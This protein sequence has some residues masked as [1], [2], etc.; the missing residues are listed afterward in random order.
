M[1]PMPK[2]TCKSQ[3]DPACLATMFQTGGATVEGVDVV[4]EINEGGAEADEVA[5][6]RVG[7]WRQ[8]GAILA[9]RAQKKATEPNRYV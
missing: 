3:T 2:E 9:R 7:L 8:V 1:Q 6:L 4:V 5:R